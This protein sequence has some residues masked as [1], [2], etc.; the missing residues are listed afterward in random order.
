MDIKKPL[1]LKDYSKKGYLQFSAN[2]F[3]D[4]K[5]CT[6]YEDGTWSKHKSVLECS[7][8]DF[9]RLEK[10]NNRTPFPCE[11]ILDVDLQE[12]ETLEQ[13]RMRFNQIIKM[14]DLWNYDYLAYFTGSKGYHIH[15]IFIDLATHGKEYRQKLRKFFLDELG[16]DLMKHSESSM[17]A[18][19]F[20]P[21]WKTGKP[22]QLLI[23]K[24]PN[25][26]WEEEVD[27]LTNG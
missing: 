4:F 17:V 2:N 19:E 24:N 9:W 22:K 3:G 1:I 5:I 12:S 10:A 26:K 15:M 13:L 6:R 14:L 25:I 11:I 20:C 27:F 23:K 18:L 21:H 7:E 16:C 8:K